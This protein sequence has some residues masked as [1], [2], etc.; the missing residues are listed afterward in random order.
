MYPAPI[1]S[2]DGGPS[3]SDEGQSSGGM[4]SQFAQAQQTKAELA[5]ARL[6]KTQ[7]ELEKYRDKE[8][9]NKLAMQKLL[10]EI[11]QL[12]LQEATQEKVIDAL[13]EALKE[14]AKLQEQWGKILA[15]FQDLAN[16]LDH[17]VGENF[18]QFDDQAKSALDARN[19]G[20]QIGRLQKK[21]LTRPA[22]EALK[23]T[24]LVHNNAF[25]YKET[26]KTHFMPLLESL[27][28][29]LALDGEKDECKM[30]DFQ[31][32]L[33]TKAQ[34]ATNYIEERSDELLEELG[35]QLN[36]LNTSEG[37]QAL[38]LET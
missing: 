12:N 35:E 11:E 37:L 1:G 36:E 17:K 32:E 3:S 33:S 30:K 13:K 6:E 28:T 9:E 29:L 24:M 10:R 19:E 31:A 15:F 34:E 25:F 23:W 20:N 5:R 8:M 7:G 21:R 26:S 38:T 4:A 16:I 2:A 18:V 14:L 22:V 27:G